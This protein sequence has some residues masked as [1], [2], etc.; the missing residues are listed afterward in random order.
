M[1]LA[2][3]LI[4]SYSKRWRNTSLPEYLP[5]YLERATSTNAYPNQ[6]SFTSSGDS[7]F[8]LLFDQF[9][10]LLIIDPGDDRQK[11]E[12]CR[13]LGAALENHSLWALFSLDEGY[14]S[15]LEPFL[16]VLPEGLRNRFRLEMLTR[17]QALEAIARPA[18]QAG[19]RFE[20]KAAD[21]LV[22]QFLQSPGLEI[23]SQ[24][25]TTE[26]IEPLL[27]QIVFSSLWEAPRRVPNQIGLRDVQLYG[28]VDEALGGFYAQVVYRSAEVSAVS[29][30]QVR[31]SIIVLIANNRTLQAVRRGLDQTEGLDNRV[32]DEL[33][34]RHLL[35]V[36][37]R[38]GET[39]YEL[40]S[41]RLIE[42]IL[43]DNDLWLQAQKETPSPG[44]E[45]ME[46]KS[47]Q[48][49]PLPMPSQD[50]R[51]QVNIEKRPG[52]ILRIS[53]EHPDYA[54]INVA[55]FRAASITGPIPQK[56]LV[57]AGQNRTVR[58]T[59]CLRNS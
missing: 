30:G 15:Q 20:A 42:P 26:R 8:L 49:G 44:P 27:L 59:A 14:L 35:K 4:S 28:N 43:K 19:V 7:R 57:S 46:S 36:E 47:Q 6:E 32:I 41:S 31:D 17:S 29:E 52:W 39:W 50:L 37:Y 21:Y 18:E 23:T 10:D 45:G 38:R 58:R 3:L 54:D 33:V 16:E 2:S 12:F 51:E 40:A 25:E 11:F 9:E 22:D 55:F 24:P 53:P 48:A 34:D 56:E 13:Q 5:Q 1:K